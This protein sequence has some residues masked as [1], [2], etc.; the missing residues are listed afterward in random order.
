MLVVLYCGS[1]SI[2][3]KFFWR[4]VCM[5]L[6]DDP[7]NNRRVLDDTVVI[8]N[9]TPEDS[10]VYQCDASNVHGSILANINIMVMSE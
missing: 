1:V 7:D 6:S 10:A 2:R 5:L 3:V 8:H 4:Y 9:A